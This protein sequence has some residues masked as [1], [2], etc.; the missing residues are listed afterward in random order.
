MGPE[1]IQCRNLDFENS[2]RL[3]LETFTLKYKTCPNSQIGSYV[4]KLG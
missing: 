3:K 2:S 1:V 4:T